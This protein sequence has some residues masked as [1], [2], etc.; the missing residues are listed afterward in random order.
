MTRAALV[1]AAKEA[2]DGLRDSRSLVSAL[3][4][5]LAGPLIVGVA[6]IMLASDR[7]I[8]RPLRVAVTGGQHAPALLQYLRQAGAVVAEARSAVESAVRE[9]GVDVALVIPDDYARKYL[10]LRPPSVRLVSDPTRPA[11]RDAGRRL[12]QMLSQYAQQTAALRLIARGINPDIVAPFRLDDVDV[13][14]ERAR[15][16]VVL[17]MLPVFLLCSAFAMG[18][19]LAIDTTAGERERGSLEPLL[20]TPTPTVA[21]SI[22]KWLTTAGFNGAGLVLTLI[23]SGAILA[24]MPLEDLGVRLGSFGSLAA[25]VLIA[26]L[27]LALLASALQILAATYAR[28]FKEG[29]TY[30]TMLVFLPM[31]T[32]MLFEFSRAK[33][34]SWRLLVPILGQHQ[35]LS[36]VL[37]G[38]SIAPAAF[39]VPGLVAI[40]STCALVRQ[41]AALLTRETIVFGR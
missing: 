5:T 21:L 23:V 10:A 13:S 19:S 1:V 4:A 29:Q 7:A 32:G 24:R 3:L 9:A 30:L 34:A 14:T 25:G 27:P 41:H 15:A 26:G 38:E 31:V 8:D 2:R 17:S 22:G 11:S 6:V 39:V 20:L 36:S 37:R 12:R 33:P 16:A 40:V 18:M 28:S 35:V